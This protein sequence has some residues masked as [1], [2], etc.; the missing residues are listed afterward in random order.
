M[1]SGFSFTITYIT[2]NG[3]VSPLQPI[4]TNVDEEYC[5]LV[6]YIHLYGREGW[7]VGA[8]ERGGARVDGGSAT[9]MN[10]FIS[11]Y[12]GDRF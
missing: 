7:T 4:R 9:Q 5:V 8:H 12:M 3:H 10:W 1:L 6:T 11:S 2:C